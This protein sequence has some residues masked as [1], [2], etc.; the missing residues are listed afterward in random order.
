M[1]FHWLNPLER[2]PKMNSYLVEKLFSF[3]VYFDI[4]YYIDIMDAM[5]NLITEAYSYFMGKPSPYAL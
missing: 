5:A 4:V 3:I 1:L 2:S